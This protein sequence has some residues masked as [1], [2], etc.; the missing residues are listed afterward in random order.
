MENGEE[1]T[2]GSSKPFQKDSLTKGRGA[3]YNSANP[4]LKQ[5]YVLEH[6]E[7]LDEPWEQ[8]VAT[9][10]FQE[11]PKTIVNEVNSPDLGL[12]YSM[13]PYQ[14]CEHGCVYCYARNTHAYWA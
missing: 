14:G 3:Q 13:N 5:E 1:N 11:T 4:F 2:G 10:F 6:I 7:G 9:Q 8:P 12:M